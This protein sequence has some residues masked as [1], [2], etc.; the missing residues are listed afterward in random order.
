MTIQ[1][2]DPRARKVKI[3]ATIGPASRDPDMLRRLFK[4]GA[5]AFRVNMSHGE[6]SVHG[7]TI[8]AIGTSGSVVSLK[9]WSTPAPSEKIAFSLGRLERSPSGCFHT[10]A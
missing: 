8:R 7:E 4:A 3:L 2:F 10:T 9:T 5:D 1:K 6:H